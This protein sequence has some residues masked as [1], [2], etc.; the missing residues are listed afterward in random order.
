MS[1]GKRGRGKFVVPLMSKNE[2]GN[3]SDRINSPDD[4]PL[5]KLSHLPIK[6][7]AGSSPK[8]I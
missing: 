2:W 6:W 3:V 5:G 7:D 4:L 8:Q 1:A